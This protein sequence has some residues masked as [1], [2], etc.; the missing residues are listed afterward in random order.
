[1]LKK[2]RH[3]I[4]GAKLIQK[5]S[6]NHMLSFVVRKDFIECNVTRLIYNQKL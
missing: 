1:M 6:S 5:V 2:F 3:N 4:F